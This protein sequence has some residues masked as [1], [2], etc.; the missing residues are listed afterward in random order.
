MKE[1][2]VLIVDDDAGMR[3]MLKNVLASEKY[4]VYTAYG[5]E[6]GVKQAL[7]LS[8]DLILL[9]LRMPGM[10]GVAVCKALREDTPRSA[11]AFC[12]IAATRGEASPPVIPSL[13]SNE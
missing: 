7:A 6:D 9:D 2:S 10:T 3:D 4:V 13:L 8:P 1:Q 5:G 11:F 12:A